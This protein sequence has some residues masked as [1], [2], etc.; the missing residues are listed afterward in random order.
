MH[1]IRREQG[2]RDGVHHRGAAH[3]EPVGG[4]RAAASASMLDDRRAHER[5]VADAIADPKVALLRA[6]VS[7][8]AR[9]TGARI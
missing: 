5:D 4:D 2:G 9:T 6:V 7:Q 1:A 3:P 8:D